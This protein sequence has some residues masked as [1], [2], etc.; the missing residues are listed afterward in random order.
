[1]VTDGFKYAAFNLPLISKTVQIYDILVERKRLSKIEL[2]SSYLRQES[3]EKMLI[4]DHHPTA[5]WIN[6]I[7]IL[8]QKSSSYQGSAKYPRVG[9][10]VQ[11]V[12]KQFIS[13][14][15][16]GTLSDLESLPIRLDMFYSSSDF[17]FNLGV[18]QDLY[19]YNTVLLCKS[20]NH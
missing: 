15:P 14:T 11:S 2:L 20:A 3:I 18:N 8:M 19:S 17:F 1:M 12:V 6:I 10:R 4:V 9:D 7:Q 13:W 5:R 16:S